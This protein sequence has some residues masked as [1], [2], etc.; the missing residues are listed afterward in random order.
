MTIDTTDAAA[1]A[2][3]LEKRKRFGDAFAEWLSTRAAIEGAEAGVADVEMDALLPVATPLNW[4][5]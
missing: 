3:V 4:R 5:L 1:V 2:D